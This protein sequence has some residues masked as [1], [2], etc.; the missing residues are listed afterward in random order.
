[1]LPLTAKW[2]NSAL[3][4]LLIVITRR[5]PA[6]ASKQTNCLYSLPKLADQHNYHFL[7][8][9]SKTTAS[10][11]DMPRGP[12]VDPPRLGGGRRLFWNGRTY[13]LNRT[14]PMSHDSCIVTAAETSNI[15]H[16]DYFKRRFAFLENIS[17]YVCTVQKNC[18]HRVPKLASWLLRDPTRS[19]NLQVINLLFIFR[20]ALYCRNIIT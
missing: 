7:V 5:I 19:H 11:Q 14:V 6:R 10:L 9:S 8:K 16:K 2:V 13:A 3:V 12:S 1:M 15:A 17:Q 4:P 18:H 20:P